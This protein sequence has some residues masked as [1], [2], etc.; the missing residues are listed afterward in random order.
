M[1]T[2][3]APTTNRPRKTTSMG[4]RS[5]CA[6]HG[7]RCR[8]TR[9]NAS[10]P[11]STMLRLGPAATDTTSTP[12]AISASATS[13][14]GVATSRASSHPMAER[15]QRLQR[16]RE[17]LHAAARLAGLVGRLGLVPVA[18]R[19]ERRPEGPLG[20]LLVQRGVDVGHVE[21]LDR[22]RPA[23]HLARL[24]PQR[25]GQR[26]VEAASASITSSPIG[27]ISFGC[28][29]WISRASHGRHSSSAS[30]GVEPRALE[31]Q[32]AVQHQ[33]VDPQALHALQDRGARAAEE[34]DAL[35]ALRQRRRSTSPA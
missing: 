20:V 27:T 19:A 15:R 12:A 25:L 10:E 8:A 18:D 32:R 24:R 4:P 31:A 29:M 1:P 28:T 22:R 33:R 21:R 16:R 3:A 2:R 26:E 6:S 30:S 13:W 9:S 7:G 14:R 35:L 23:L 5:A 34:R 11:S 17:R